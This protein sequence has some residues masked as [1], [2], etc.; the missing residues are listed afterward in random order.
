LEDEFAVIKGQQQQPTAANSSKTSKKT[1]G[2][3][4]FL[5]SLTLAIFLKP[6]KSLTHLLAFFQN[7]VQN[8]TKPSL[9]L[10]DTRSSIVSL[11]SQNQQKHPKDHTLYCHM[12]Q[13]YKPSHG[14]QQKMNSCSH[15]KD[16]SAVAF[17]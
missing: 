14:N 10:L 5:S 8:T 15:S 16:D 3:L 6:T 12:K 2:P 11:S 13:S 9:A 17:C 1:L 7:P 4:I